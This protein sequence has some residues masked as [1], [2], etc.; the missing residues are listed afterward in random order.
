MTQRNFNCDG[1][2]RCGDE[3]LRLIENKYPKIKTTV[4]KKNPV[5]NDLQ[6]GQCYFPIDAPQEYFEA[7]CSEQAVTVNNF[8]DAFTKY[9]FRRTDDVSRALDCRTYAMAG[10]LSIKGKLC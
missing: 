9:G 10:M 2:F 3:V 7:L 4:L 6:V 8:W 5:F 1:G